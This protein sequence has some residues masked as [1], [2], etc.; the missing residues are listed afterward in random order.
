VCEDVLKYYTTFIERFNYYSTLVKAS[1]DELYYWLTQS[2]EESKGFTC[3]FRDLTNSYEFS[4][5]NDLIKAFIEVSSNSVKI[6]LK[7][8]SSYPIM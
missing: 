2:I 3:D 7:V 4:Y 5:F 8:L 6:I 1:L